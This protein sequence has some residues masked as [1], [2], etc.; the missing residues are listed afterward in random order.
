MPPQV[1]TSVIAEVVD[2][3][4]PSAVKPVEYDADE[5]AGEIAEAEKEFFFE[6][7]I[8]TGKVQQF[9]VKE[10]SLDPMDVIGAFDEYIANKNLDIKGSEKI[11][12]EAYFGGYRYCFYIQ[13]GN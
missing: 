1:N 10:N 9:D 8:E 13:K 4:A 7:Y 12:S 3:T 11:D 6:Q 2:T 5:Y